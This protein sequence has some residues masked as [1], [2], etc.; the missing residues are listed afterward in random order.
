M[1]DDALFH[2][3]FWTLLAG[4]MGVRVL[5]LVQVRSSGGRFMPDR[6]AIDREGRTAFLVRSV[7]F[8]L[9]LGL[10]VA[11]A[12]NPPSMRALDSALP[13]PA[14]WLGFA[15]GLVAVALAAW[16]QV[17][18]GGQWSAQLQL[19][20]RHQLITSGPYARIRH[21]IYAALILLS[22][23]FALITANWFFILIGEIA[24]IVALDRIPRE[25][26]MMRDGVP[27]YAAY[28]SKVRFRLL[29][30]VW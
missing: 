23:G 15:F 5:S 29:P 18:L 2:G 7:G 3:L 22:I 11:Y 28:A 21:P 12:L 13:I 19:T 8:F 10:L 1:F 26:R 20:E 14:R 6:Q 9:I 30:R 16:A 27:G 4:M 17:T 24:I 25:E